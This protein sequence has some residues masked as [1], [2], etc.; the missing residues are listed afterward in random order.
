MYT[1][2]YK[3]PVLYFNRCIVN[4]WIGYTNAPSEAKAKSNLAFRFKRENGYSPSAKIV[5]P[6]EIKMEVVS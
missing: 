3:G 2:S 6:G 4:E 1:W 5:L